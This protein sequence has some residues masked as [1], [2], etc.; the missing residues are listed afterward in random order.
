MSAVVV[1]ED[2]K[3]RSYSRW[4]CGAVKV[5]RVFPG[6]RRQGAGKAGALVRGL[7]AAQWASAR[8]SGA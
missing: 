5:V 3:A 7:D 6:W 1:L 2:M 4:C 8:A